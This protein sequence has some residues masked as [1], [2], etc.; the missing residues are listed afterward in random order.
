[1]MTAAEFDRAM[2]V[3]L[4][5]MG[6]NLAKDGHLSTVT[7]GLPPTG[8]NVSILAAPADEEPTTIKIPGTTIPIYTVAGSF[9]DNLDLVREI[10]TRHGVYGAIT[11]SEAWMLT[12]QAAAHAVATHTKA[13]AH[14]ARKE[15]AMVFG[16][17]P[18]LR[19]WRSVIIPMVRGPVSAGSAFM[20]TS[21][22]FVGAAPNPEGGPPT[23]GAVKLDWENRIE[24]RIDPAD[25]ES[26]VRVS[27]W[28][29]DVLD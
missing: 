16:A 22:T 27:N 6:V 25:P 12:G 4:T 8:E 7:M 21:P 15:M 11:I 24:D 13:A 20:K 17:A 10:F 2:E 9:I 18:K 29:L 14:P 5:R 19:Y 1:M 26:P 3:V 23:V 28:L